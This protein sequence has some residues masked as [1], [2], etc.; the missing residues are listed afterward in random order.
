[1]N[2]VTQD[3][4]IEVLSERPVKIMLCTIGLSSEDIR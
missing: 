3:K 4:D 1:M 2:S